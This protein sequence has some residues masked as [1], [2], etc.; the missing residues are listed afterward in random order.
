[1][2]K[3]DRDLN[4]IHGTQRINARDHATMLDDSFDSLC[5]EVYRPI[6]GACHVHTHTSI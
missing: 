1:M 3:V 2:D 4:R 6:S 5:I